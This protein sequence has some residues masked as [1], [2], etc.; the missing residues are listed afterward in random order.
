M[1]RH[2]F[3][4]TAH[5]DPQLLLRI[6]ELLSSPN[7]YFIVNID[8]KMKEHKKWAKY[9]SGI[10]PNCFFMHRSVAHGG[11]SQVSTTIRM[12]QE[13]SNFQPDYFHLISGQDFPCKSIY[14]FDRY[15][16]RHKGESYM[17]YD[18]QSQ[19]AEW[20]VSK[21]PPPC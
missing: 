7:H 17:L 6:M 21:Y 16:E 3:L 20:S 19:H 18:L 12:L 10:I 9:I 11:Y 2:A 4:I 1:L 15:F 14:E 13:A 8:R 5:K